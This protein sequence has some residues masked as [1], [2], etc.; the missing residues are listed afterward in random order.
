MTKNQKIKEMRSDWEKEGKIS[1]VPKLVCCGVELKYRKN[2]LPREVRECEG[3]KNLCLG[4]F[5]DDELKDCKNFN[6]KR[7]SAEEIYLRR[8]FGRN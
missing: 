1:F 3:C 4:Q 8:M 2:L 5:I 6:P 7:R